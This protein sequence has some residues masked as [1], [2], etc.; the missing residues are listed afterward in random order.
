MITFTYTYRVLL[1]LR[2]PYC[3]VLTSLGLIAGPPTTERGSLEH[4]SRSCSEH[5]RRP[6]CHYGCCQLLRVVLPQYA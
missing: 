1:K 6:W 4:D 3:F 2:L 5:G